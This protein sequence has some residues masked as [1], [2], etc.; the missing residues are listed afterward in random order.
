M[1]KRLRFKPNLEVGHR[2]KKG[3]SFSRRREC[4]PC[5]LRKPW[6]CLTF[7]ELILYF[8]ATSRISRTFP[9]T[10]FFERVNQQLGCPC[11]EEPPCFPPIPS[12]NEDQRRGYQAL[13]QP[14]VHFTCVSMNLRSCAE[15]RQLRG[16]R[17]AGPYQHSSEEADNGS[18]AGYQA[19]T[20]NASRQTANT[21]VSD[22]VIVRGGR[23]GSCCCRTVSFRLSA[24]SVLCLIGRRG[25]CGKKPERKSPNAITQH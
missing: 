8:T 20:S 1:T 11:G 15:P 21:L 23:R 24:V 17:A 4:D 13:H 6:R 2:G 16:D 9:P 12:S 22:D 3:E 19:L 7:T 10:S 14:P 5:E 25:C 18:S